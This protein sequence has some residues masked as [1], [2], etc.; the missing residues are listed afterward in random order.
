[1]LAAMLPEATMPELCDPAPG[2]QPATSVAQ[3][4]AAHV[5]EKRQLEPTL[6]SLRASGN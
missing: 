2:A 5:L 4:I 6:S 3:A 1:M